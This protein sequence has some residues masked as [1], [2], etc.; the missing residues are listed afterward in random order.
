EMSSS[1]HGLLTNLEAPRSIRR[2][3]PTG[4]KVQL[5]PPPMPQEWNGTMK[6]IAHDPSLAPATYFG[7][8]FRGRGLTSPYNWPTTNATP[9]HE[10]KGPEWQPGGALYNYSRGIDLQ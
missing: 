5:D 10:R 8:R 7:D 9:I 4:S 3:T 1:C 2:R 6:S